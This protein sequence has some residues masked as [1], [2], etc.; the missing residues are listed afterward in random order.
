MIGWMPHSINPVYAS[1]RFRCFYPLRSLHSS[2]I[3]CELYDKSR[4]ESYNTVVIQELLC[5]Q[6]DT[7]P[8]PTGAAIVQEMRRLKLHG[9]KLV[10]DSCDNHLHQTKPNENWRVA[11]ENLAEMFQL[12]DHLVFSTVT[13][14]EELL[15]KIP[16]TI[17]F[18]VIGDAVES[19]SDLYNV[20]LWRQMISKHY[21]SSAISAYQLTKCLAQ[22]RDDGFCPIVWFGNHGTSYA[23]GGM[24]SLDGFRDLLHRLSNEVCPLSLTVISNNKTKFDHVTSNWKIPTHYCDWSRPTF[25]RLLKLHDICIIPIERSPYTICKT[26]NRLATALSCGLAVVADSIPSYLEFKDCC[27]LDDWEQGLTNYLQNSDKR[28]KDVLKGIDK[29]NEHFSHDHIAQL[30]KNLFQSL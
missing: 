9:V 22:T 23:G 11:A 28:Q 24:E 30:W 3:P 20:P 8:Y 4:S 5:L 16:S 26:N 2:S 17:P 12:A 10:V 15:K 21:F 1:V 7:K 29:I 25:Y 19:S 18:S 13:L 27:S 6:D 14:S